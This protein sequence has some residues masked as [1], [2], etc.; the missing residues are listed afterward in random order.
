MG[1]TYYEWVRDLYKDE[2]A[3]GKE[4]AAVVAVWQAPKGPGSRIS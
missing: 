3:A 4:P 2:I 1:S